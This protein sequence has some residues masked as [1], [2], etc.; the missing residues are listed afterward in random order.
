VGGQT[1]KMITARAPSDFD[2]RYIEETDANPAGNYIVFRGLTGP[3]QTITFPSVKGHKRPAI[4]ALQIIR[5][6]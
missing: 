5:A 4:N 1:R 3:K 2:G 6:R